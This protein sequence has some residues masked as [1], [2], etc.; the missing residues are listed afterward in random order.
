LDDPNTN[1]SNY[2][3]GRPSWHFKKKPSLVPI[4]ENRSSLPWKSRNFLHLKVIPMSLKD[5]A[6]AVRIDAPSV[7]EIAAEIR[8]EV[9]PGRC[10]RQFAHSAEKRLRS[11]SSPEA[12][13]RSIAE[14][15]TLKANRSI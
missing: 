10:S 2:L 12:I 4:V 3:G 7:M 13:N 14:T 11:P 15:V 6:L 1:P 5:A 8:T 9:G